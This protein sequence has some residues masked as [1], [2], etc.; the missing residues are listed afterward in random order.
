MSSKKFTL[1]L[2]DFAKIG[3]N[4]IFVGSA[5]ALTYIAQNVGEIDMGTMGALFVPII[6]AGLDTA[7]KWLKSNE[8]NGE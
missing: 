8:K 1:N 3:R 5:A 6:A 4:A 7:I 2:A